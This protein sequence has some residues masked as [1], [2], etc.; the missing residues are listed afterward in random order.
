MAVE[1]PGSISDDRIYVRLL[2]PVS[3]SM[4]ECFANT[5]WKKES[6]VDDS[7]MGLELEVDETTRTE[8][9]KW[10]EAQKNMKSVSHNFIRR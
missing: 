8:I 7:L 9:R 6:K 1:A 4:V 10:L 2:I 3:N 5:K